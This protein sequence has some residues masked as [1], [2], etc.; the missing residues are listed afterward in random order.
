MLGSDAGIGGA[1]PMGFLAPHTGACLPLIPAP[2]LLSGVLPNPT[3]KL[4]NFAPPGAVWSS[5]GGH[6]APRQGPFPGVC[7]PSPALLRDVCSWGQVN[8]NRSPGVGCCC[9]HP[10]P[11]TPAGAAPLAPLH[12]AAVS[13]IQHLGAGSR[14]PA[15]SHPQKPRGHRHAPSGSFIA[16]S[17]RHPGG[18]SPLP[19]SSRLP[20]AFSGGAVTRRRA[21]AIP[22]GGSWR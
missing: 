7:K 10:A 15:P 22:G 6:F 2:T 17:P 16:T 18:S 14:Q 4:I 13:W 12:P 19:P 1:F 8:R 3:E 5:C 9:W 20:T 11:P 21:G